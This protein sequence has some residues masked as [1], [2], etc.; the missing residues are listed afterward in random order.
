MDY[1]YI[2]F[3]GAES[4]PISFSMLTILT[5]S[6]TVNLIEKAFLYVS[7]SIALNLKLLFNLNYTITTDLLINFMRKVSFLVF[8]QENI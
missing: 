7:Y 8:N 5:C 2:L 1:I 3:G 4:I 6:I